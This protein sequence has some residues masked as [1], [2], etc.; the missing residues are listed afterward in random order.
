MK[1]RIPPEMDALLWAAAESRDPQA[2]DQFLERHPQYKAELTERMET[3]RR[4]RSAK[5]GASVIPSFALRPVPATPA[6]TYVAPMAVVAAGIAI[7]IGTN[8]NQI[9]RQEPTAPATTTMPA[10]REMRVVPPQ[11]QE[12][13]GEAKSGNDGG[14]DQGY[15]GARG[16]GSIPG[17]MPPNAEA[18]AAKSRAF[19]VRIDDLPLATAIKT[20]AATGKVDVTMD[21]KMPDV[22][23]S[24]DYHGMTALQML[25]DMGA[26][27]GFTA[28]DEGNHQIIIIPATEAR[29][30]SGDTAKKG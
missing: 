19:D 24:V 28:F 11:H 10:Q 15:P 13:S 21:P 26:R 20:I 9:A 23:V 3:V 30:G 1:S 12:Y 8:L 5:P 17:P 7:W 29:G 16:A 4:M 27:F 18:T 2:L 14:V 22:L 25:Q 6:W